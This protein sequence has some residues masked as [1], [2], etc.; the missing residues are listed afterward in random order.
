MSNSAIYYNTLNPPLYGNL[1]EDI[2]TQKMSIYNADAKGNIL[3]INNQN[4]NSNL[5]S[6]ITLSKIYI[7]FPNINGN[8]KI[9]DI[10]N[11]EEVYKNYSFDNPRYTNINTNAT[12]FVYKNMDT[13]VK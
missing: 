1:I 8:I 5:D 7:D 2:Y 3:Y 9:G 12:H 6:N 10:F 13:W 4:K 11:L